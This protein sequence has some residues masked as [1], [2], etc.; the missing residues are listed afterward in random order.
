M[1][2]LALDQRQ[3]KSPTRAFVIAWAF[4][5]VFYLLEY[6]VRSSP[7]VM[8]SELETSFNT[9][10][11]FTRAS[12]TYCLRLRASC[13]ACLIPIDPHGDQTGQRSWVVARPSMR[14]LARV[15]VL[16]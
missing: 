1:A 16:G 14:T 4:T 11:W 6:A 15:L 5:V 8:I 3:S 7:A 12:V 9:N 2:T 13:S 10:A